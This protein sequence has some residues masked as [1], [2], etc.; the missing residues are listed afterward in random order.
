[1]N[2]GNTESGSHSLLDFGANERLLASAEEARSRG[3]ELARVTAVHRDAMDLRSAAG[4]LR[5]ECSGALLFSTDDDHATPVTG[6]WVLARLFIDSGLGIVEHVLPRRGVLRRK[7][8]GRATRYQLLA[9]HVDRAFILTAADED[10][11]VNRIERYLVMVCDGGIEP[12]VL[13]SKADVADE[14]RRAEQREQLQRLG[15]MRIVYFS[16]MSGE[17]MDELRTLIEAGRTVCLLG[18]SGVGKSTLINVLL[19]EQRERTA[20][21]R[22]QDHKGRH[23]TTTRAMHLLPGG[24]VLIDTPGMRELGHIGA[25]DGLDAVFDDISALAADCRYDDCR[26]EAEP[27]CAVR[28]A[29]ERGDIDAARYE[30][31]LRIRRDAER[32]DVS[33]AERRRRERV[34]GRLLKNFKDKRDR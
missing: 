31:F 27:G 21:V 26:H 17:G 5:G 30:N 9:A 23:T 34:F 32:L 13:I 14:A 33:V 3:L 28:A 7:D 29:V 15:A 24:G 20:E 6:D 22:T 8:P 10:F 1:M 4:E 16:S 18:S 2:N 25:Q 11:S 12:V 19:G